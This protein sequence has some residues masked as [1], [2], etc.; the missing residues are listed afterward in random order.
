MND[1][2]KKI[3]A[4]DIERAEKLLRLRGEWG[5]MLA[6]HDTANID[7]DAVARWVD[8]H[9]NGTLPRSAL[10]LDPR[11]VPALNTIAVHFFMVGILC[12]RGE[13]IDR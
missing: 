11:V 2:D 12:G 3:S 13:G 4:I 7:S 8:H 10:D 5:G 1:R 6:V 9:I